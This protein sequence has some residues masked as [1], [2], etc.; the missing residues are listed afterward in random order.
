MIILGLYFFKFTDF[1][2]LKSLPSVSIFNKSISLF[3]YLLLS[4]I[5]LRV[6]VCIKF[7]SFFLPFLMKVFTPYFN[8]LTTFT[9]NFLSEIGQQIF[10]SSGLA[11]LKTLILSISISIFITRQFFFCKANKY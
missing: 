9:L 1:K 11:I 7:S 8:R 2:T 10:K 4:I 6:F 5:S 3:L